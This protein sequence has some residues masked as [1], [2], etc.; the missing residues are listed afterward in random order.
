M[1]NRYTF[2]WS[3]YR[4]RYTKDTPLVYH[5]EPMGWDIL[6]TKFQQYRIMCGTNVIGDNMTKAEAEAMKKLLE[7]S[8]E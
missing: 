3:D 2:G 8:N 6:P 5:I 7:A 1:S 4:G